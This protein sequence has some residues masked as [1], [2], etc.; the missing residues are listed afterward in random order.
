MEKRVLALTLALLLSACARSDTPTSRGDSFSI[1]AE[2]RSELLSFNG[3]PVRSCLPSVLGLIAVR[4]T[5]TNGPG[6]AEELDRHF[7][8]E[9]NTHC[10]ISQ[11][12]F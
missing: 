6:M 3:Q 9:M 5:E 11:R 4:M 10:K 1:D 7:L 12:N 2:L 8:I